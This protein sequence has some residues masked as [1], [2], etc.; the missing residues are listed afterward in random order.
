MKSEK[1]VK[2]TN[3]WNSCIYTFGKSAEWIIVLNQEI[4]TSRE[5]VP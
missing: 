5:Y 4:K 1:S 2:N 3:N